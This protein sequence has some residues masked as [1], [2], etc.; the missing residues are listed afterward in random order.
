MMMT[1]LLLTGA[2]AMT[3]AACAPVQR[4]DIQALARDYCAA[5]V[6]NDEA[7]AEAL[8]GTGLRATVARARA[9][10][11]AF[12]AAHPGDKPPLGDG[13][14]LAA[15]PDVPS[16]CTPGVA[17]KD[18]VTVCYEIAGAP[19]AGWQDRLDVERTDGDVKIADVRFAPHFE[20]RLSQA[21]EAIAR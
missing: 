12:E 20:N 10:N 8:M 1:R 11:S 17:G 9:A 7:R 3:V 13:L 2:T 5:V 4:E 19:D 18:S 21:L 14:P 15:F 6:A 16:T